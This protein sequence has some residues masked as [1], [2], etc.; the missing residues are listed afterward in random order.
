MRDG[1][2]LIDNS[3]FNPWYKSRQG[4]IKDEYWNDYKNSS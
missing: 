4:E 1:N 2:V 3:T